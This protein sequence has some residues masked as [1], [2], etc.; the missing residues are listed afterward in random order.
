M[1]ILIMLIGNL[2]STSVEQAGVISRL[3]DPPALAPLLYC[4]DCLARW[5]LKLV[6]TFAIEV[7]TEPTDF[8]LVGSG[9]EDHHLPVTLKPDLQ[10]EVRL[11]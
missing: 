10:P 5:V 4:G 6:V 3:I 7:T 9:Q 2:F 1:I 8:A 11:H